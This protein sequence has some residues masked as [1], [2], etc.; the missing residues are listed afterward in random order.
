[1]NVA[2]NMDCMEAMRQMPDCCIDLVVTSPPYDDLRTYNGY[3]FD[4]KATIKEL[5]RVMTDG[6]VAVWIVA[7]Q[8]KDGTESGTSFRQA[9]WAKECGFNLHDT[10]IWEKDA[11]SFPDTNRYYGVFEY[12]FVFSKGPPKTANMICDRENLYAGC[13]IHGTSRQR[14][15]TLK[16]NNGI[17]A[18]RSIPEKGRRFN[19]WRISAEKHNITGHPAVFPLKLAKDHI[20]TWSNEGDVVMDPFL[21]S[22]TTRIAAYDTGRQFVGFEIDKDYF[23][24]QEERFRAHTAQMS[25]FVGGQE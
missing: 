14:D 5:Y 16:P 19:V 9:L 3:V 2:Y 4:W 12:M 13:S 21:G 23:D 11:F 20:L 22:G 24:K 15:G 10:M 1:M 17:K 7:D 8:T 6:G 18:G 25:L